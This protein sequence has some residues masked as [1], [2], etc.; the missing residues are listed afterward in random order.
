VLAMRSPKTMRQL[1]KV[2]RPGDSVAPDVE[3]G[4]AGTSHGRIGAYLLG[5]WGLEYPLVEAV[6]YHHDPSSVGSSSFD[7]PTILH[8]ADA[9]AHEIE[10]E[11]YG[12]KAEVALD[13]EHLA[14]IGVK[15]KLEAWRELGRE[16]WDR[17]S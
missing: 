1:I 8:V 11:R 12:R 5:L 7:L 2:K 14:R 17:E 4:I 6:A 10:N 16:L 3:E 13:L 15:D 9:L